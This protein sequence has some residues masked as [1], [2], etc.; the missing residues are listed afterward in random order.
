MAT[1]GIAVRIDG[2]SLFLL[3]FCTGYIGMCVKR[4]KRFGW[5]R[6]KCRL[7]VARVIR[8]ELARR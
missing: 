2:D 1:P 3:I 5:A 7:V 6:N 4:G 8:S